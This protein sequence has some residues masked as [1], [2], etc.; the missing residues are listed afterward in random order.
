MKNNEF[1]T[2]DELKRIAEEC[3]YVL[4]RL[5]GDFKLKRRDGAKYITISGSQKNRIWVSVTSYCDER[6]FNMVKAGVKFA[7]TPIEEREDEKKRHL[8]HL[9]LSGINGDF[10]NL[11][12][13]DGYMYLDDKKNRDYKK[14]TFT[15][16]EID[17]IKEKYNTDL[18]DFE[19][20]EVKE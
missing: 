13:E 2:I 7:E 6:D 16:K 10:L 8:K 9:W 20:K 19:E 4:S 15:Q 12:L 1:M 3:D 17:K 14:T 11:D 18:S 5:Y